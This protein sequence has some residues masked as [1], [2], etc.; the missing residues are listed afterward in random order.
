MPILVGAMIALAA[1]VYNAI[2]AAGIFRLAFFLTAITLIVGA[3]AVTQTLLVTLVSQIDLA[4]PA[5]L[6]TPLSWIVPDNLDE[7]ISA[8]ITAAVGVAVYQWQYNIL[9]AAAAR[10]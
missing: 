6:I 4:L 1:S 7:L 9:V 2:R 3:F 10:S 5:Y 8:R